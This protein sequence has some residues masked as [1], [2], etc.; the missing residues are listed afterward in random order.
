MLAMLE[1]KKTYIIAFLGAALTLVMEF[2]I[3]I[4]PVV[5][6]VLGFLGLGALR[7]GVTKT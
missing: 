6:Q 4:P 2:G 1:G 5:L 3:E 7:A